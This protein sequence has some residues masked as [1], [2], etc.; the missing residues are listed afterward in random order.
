MMLEMQEKTLK[1]SITDSRKLKR[2][3][4]SVACLKTEEKILKRS[5][6]DCG[7]QT[8]SVRTQFL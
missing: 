7:W 5:I 3:C 1:R 2:R 4:W 6:S 8:L